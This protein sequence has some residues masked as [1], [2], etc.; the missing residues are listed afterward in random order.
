M[1]CSQLRLMGVCVVMVVILHAVPSNRSPVRPIEHLDHFV[2]PRDWETSEGDPR[3]Q[4]VLS[5]RAGAGHQ[6]HQIGQFADLV[7]RQRG[8]P[9]GPESEPRR[10]STSLGSRPCGLAVSSRAWAGGQVGRG[11][12]WR[13]AAVVGLAQVV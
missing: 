2:D 1:L 9:A 12:V 8:I 7:P 13:L 4:G 3:I 5:M 6:N 10:A 11:P